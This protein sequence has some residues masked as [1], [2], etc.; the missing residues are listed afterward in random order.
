MTNCWEFVKFV[1][2][3]PVKILRNTVVVTMY[4]CTKNDKMHQQLVHS[5]MHANDGDGILLIANYCNKL[6]ATYNVHC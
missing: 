6:L 1:N 5:V 2:I 4:V 3:S